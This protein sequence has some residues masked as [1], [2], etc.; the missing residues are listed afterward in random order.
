MGELGYQL[1]GAKEIAAMLGVPEKTVLNLYRAG[2]LPGVKIGR[3][4]R[5]IPAEIIST[6]ESAAADGRTI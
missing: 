3:R 6:V 5:F 2:R 1:L 4:V